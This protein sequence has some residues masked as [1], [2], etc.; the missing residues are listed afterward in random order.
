MRMKRFVFAAILA[1][2]AAACGGDDDGAQ[3]TNGQTT[4]GE[5]NV[6]EANDSLKFDP[7]TITVAVGQ[8]VTWKNVG[9]AP[10]TVTFKGGGLDKQFNG[11][12]TVT[13]TFTSAGTTDYTC[14]I[15]PGMAGTV[16]V[17]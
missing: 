14:T 2:A 15:H 7:A 10:H 3:P 17:Q 11:G 9:S 6:V 13:F 4:P 1:L 16:V 12:E 8:T 5:G